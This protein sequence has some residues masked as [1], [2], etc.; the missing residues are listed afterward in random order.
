MF[1]ECSNCYSRGIFHCANLEK[2]VDMG[3]FKLAKILINFVGFYAFIILN[4]CI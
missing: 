3:I 2:G 1:D 4:I